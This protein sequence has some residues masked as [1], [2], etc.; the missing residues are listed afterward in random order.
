MNGAGTGM[1]IT[2][3]VSRIIREAHHW[4]L[5]VCVGVVAGAGLLLAAPVILAAAPTTSAS[6]LP[7]VL[8]RIRIFGRLSVSGLTRFGILSGL[9]REI[10]GENNQVNF[11]NLANPDYDSKRKTD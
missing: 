2:A 9:R 1:E 6:A 5:T 3:V 8:N 4:A 11:F 10:R 7:A